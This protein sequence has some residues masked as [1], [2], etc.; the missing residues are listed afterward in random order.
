VTEHDFQLIGVGLYSVP[1]ARRLTGMPSAAINRW[2]RGYARRRDGERVEYPP[3][4][5]PELPVIEDETAISFRDLMELRFINRL[6][7]LDISWL[8]IRHTVETIRELMQT[9]HPF[10]TRRFKTDG[11]RVYAVLAKESTLLRRRQL[12]FGAVFERSLFAELEYEGETV[13][14]WRPESGGNIVIL[15]PARSFGKP[16]VDEY[17]VPTRTLAAAVRAEGSIDRVADWYD[18]PPHVV[19][20]ALAYEQYLQAA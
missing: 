19:R 3:L 6:R 16:I 12:A 13:A 14:R 11:K 5:P 1:E 7:A 8:E 18:V 10:T 20:T 9:Q 2:V 4:V 17:D 15:D